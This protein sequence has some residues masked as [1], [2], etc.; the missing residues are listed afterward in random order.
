[1]LNL[2]GALPVEGGLP[3]MVDG[4]LIGAIGVSGVQSAQDGI[5][6]EAGAA[7]AATFKL[8]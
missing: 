3:L 4:E 1:M 8:S 6:A 5:I 2:P 7:L